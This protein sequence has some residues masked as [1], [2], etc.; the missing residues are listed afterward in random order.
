MP[1]YDGIVKAKCVTVGD[2]TVTGTTHAAL[3]VSWGDSGVDS[4]FE[5]F[6]NNN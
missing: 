1:K 4:V 2:Y 3:V 5:R 6:I